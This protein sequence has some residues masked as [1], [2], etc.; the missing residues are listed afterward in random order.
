MSQFYKILSQNPVT[1]HPRKQYQ[2][3]QIHMDRICLMVRQNTV[4][5]TVSINAKNA[6]KILKV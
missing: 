3:F 6:E 4:C 1:E 2:A 5:H